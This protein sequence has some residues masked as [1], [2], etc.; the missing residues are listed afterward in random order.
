MKL[1]HGLGKRGAKKPGCPLIMVSQ[2]LVALR[3]LRKMSPSGVNGQILRSVICSQNVRSWRRRR[4]GGLPAMIAELIAPIDTP[5]TQ[6]GS[7]PA[8]C[9]A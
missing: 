9:I 7:M 5:D 2:E 4:P 3:A 6:S 8:S 1:S